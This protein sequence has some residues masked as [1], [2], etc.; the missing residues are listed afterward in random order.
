VVTKSES[1]VPSRNS[2]THSGVPLE[3]RA[4][5]REVGG[6]L[7]QGGRVRGSTPTSWEI[8]CAIKGRY[9]DKRGFHGGEEWS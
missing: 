3:K 7:P 4:G 8:V 5:T 2:L 1:R 6:L 9:A